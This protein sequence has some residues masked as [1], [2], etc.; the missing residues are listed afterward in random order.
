M[1]YRAPAAFASRI[2]ASIR[3]RLP[4]K[5]SAHWLRLHVATVYSFVLTSVS[6]SVLRFL[7]K[8]DMGN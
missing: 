1:R 5:S 3:A 2:D 7:A 6:T 4:G 8:K